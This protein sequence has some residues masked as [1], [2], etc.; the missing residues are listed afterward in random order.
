MQFVEN[1]PDVPDR[2]IEAHEDGRVVF[3][4]GAGISYPVGLPT[5][6]GLVEKIYQ[7]LGETQNEIE[8]SAFDSNLFDTT[9]N[10]ILKAFGR[11]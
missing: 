10:D 8:K 6:K 11:G 4:C 5:F 2:L 1:G 3:F 9:L 7:S